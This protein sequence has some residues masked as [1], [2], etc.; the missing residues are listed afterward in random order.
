MKFLIFLVLL[1]SCFA[2]EAADTP[3]PK[4]SA[5]AGSKAEDGKG[6]AKKESDTTGE[7]TGKT[8]AEGE[9]EKK[10]K[11]ELPEEFTD[12]LGC[13][14]CEYVADRLA[15]FAKTISPTEKSKNLANRTAAAQ[16]LVNY[17]CTSFWNHSIFGIYGPARRRQF[18]DVNI[19]SVNPKSLR[20]LTTGEAQDQ[21]F[22]A[23]CYQLTTA[24][25]TK[26][27]SIIRP[28]Y[29]DTSRHV[30]RKRLCV[31]M[32]GY[33]PK[34]PKKPKKTLK[35]KKTAGEKCLVKAVDAIAKSNWDAATKHLK[36]ATS[37]L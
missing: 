25:A 36:C 24:H 15:Y 37:K 27:V 7:P 35:A 33:C 34:A 31:N 30:I 16:N 22:Y 9:G 1:A 10:A 11:F 18:I 19:S 21:F 6:A 2:E 32:A 29:I 28:F 26:L 3:T 12:S 5:P 14:A 20:N 23:V 17:T 8:E 13:S 4:D